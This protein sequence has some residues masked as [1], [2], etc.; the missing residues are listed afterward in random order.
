[1]QF[2]TQAPVFSPGSHGKEPEI[3]YGTSTVLDGLV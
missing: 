3:S 1:M 2:A